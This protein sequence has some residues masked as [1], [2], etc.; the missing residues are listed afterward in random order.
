MGRGVLCPNPAAEFVYQCA[1]VVGLGVGA[2]GGCQLGLRIHACD[3]VGR[4]TDF[5]MISMVQSKWTSN[6]TIAGRAY[7]ARRGAS[8]VI[9]KWCAR[10]T[11]TP[12]AGATTRRACSSSSGTLTPSR[13]S[14]SRRPPSGCS[15]AAAGDAIRRRVLPQPH[16]HRGVQ[17]V[18][19]LGALQKLAARSPAHLCYG[20]AVRRAEYLRLHLRPQRL[21]GLRRWAV[22]SG[23]GAVGTTARRRTRRT[24]SAGATLCLPWSKPYDSSGGGPR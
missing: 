10:A 4:R 24:W 1:A 23:W 20:P 11:T 8:T 21:D 7:M 13:C 9:A 12:S 18:Q 19:V 6:E 14:T 2:R 17:G 22:S 5:S 15:R 3:D 16:E